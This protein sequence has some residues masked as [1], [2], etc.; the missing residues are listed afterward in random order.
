MS[1]KSWYLLHIFFYL[2][3]IACFINDTIHVV[4]AIQSLDV[5]CSL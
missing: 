2:A 5:E 1:D 4:D 3:I